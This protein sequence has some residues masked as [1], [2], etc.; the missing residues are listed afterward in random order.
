MHVPIGKIGEHAKHT[1]GTHM[2]IIYV[3]NVKVDI[4]IHEL[5][6]SIRS[7]GSYKI[8]IDVPLKY[9]KFVVRP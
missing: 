2:S 3:H 7:G 8:K 1:A 9:T 5:N 4:Q 6:Q